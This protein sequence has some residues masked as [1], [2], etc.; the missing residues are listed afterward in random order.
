[1]AKQDF[2]I[3]KSHG[4]AAVGR[5]VRARAI[6]PGDVAFLMAVAVR[7]DPGVLHAVVSAKEIGE[8]LGIGQS[9]AA[10]SARRLEQAAL[11]ARLH[12]DGRRWIVNPTV[13][14]VCAARREKEAM[15]KFQAARAAHPPTFALKG[16]HNHHR[17]VTLGLKLEPITSEAQLRE[18]YA[19]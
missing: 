1:M 16:D 9:M 3:F 19:S 8:E 11:L 5:A 2:C 10:R 15:A 13:A 17:R 12:E 7:M 14:V 18:I 4:Q 6:A